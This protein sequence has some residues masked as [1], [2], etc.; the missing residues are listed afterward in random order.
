MIEPDLTTCPA[1]AEVGALL[2]VL[3]TLASSAHR[4]A[5]VALQRE[6]TEFEQ[7]LQ[8]VSDIVWTWREREWA[9]EKREENA[10]RARGERVEK[11]PVEEGTERVGR[12]KLATTKWRI[13]LLEVEI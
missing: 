4:T 8:T 5:A 6:L 11:P 9:E 12:P 2:R 10:Q 3:L 13:G 7:R 1:A